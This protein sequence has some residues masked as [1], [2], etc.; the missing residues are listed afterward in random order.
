M[1]RTR[2]RYGKYFS[3]IGLVILIT[4]IN[5]LKI[6]IEKVDNMQEHMDNIRREMKLLRK[7][8]KKVLNVKYMEKEIM[9]AFDR[10]IRRV[11]MVKKNSI[12]ELKD[13]SVETSQTEKLRKG[14]EGERETEK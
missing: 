8:R 13:M 11:D 4:M 10:L 14:R 1:I 3:I 12:S 5:M 7:N 2:L 6:L 9:N